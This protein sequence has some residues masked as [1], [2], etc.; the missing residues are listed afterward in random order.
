[1]DFARIVSVGWISS[2]ALRVESWS[3]QFWLRIV[4]MYR[5]LPKSTIEW[6]LINSKDSV[7]VE[8][9]WY[10]WFIKT[11][12]WVQVISDVWWRILL[13]RRICLIL[14]ELGAHF[15][16]VFKSF[17][18]QNFCCF[19]D[20]PDL[21]CW[22]SLFCTWYWKTC[23]CNRKCVRWS[24]SLAVRKSVTDVACLGFRVKSI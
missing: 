9:L 3:R 7:L 8:R 14:E 20:S 13:N 6:F 23:G 16:S 1:M 24:K 21:G 18:V 19:C 10:F 5:G 15:L 4:Y 17:F 12:W 2:R 11:T 22:L